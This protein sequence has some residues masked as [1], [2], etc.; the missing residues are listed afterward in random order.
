MKKILLL[1]GAL[2]AT[3]ATE[4]QAQRLSF[5]FSIGCSPPPQVYVAPAPV[6]IAP[7]PV[8]YAAPQPVYV[9]PQ[10]V[11][12]APAPV[13]VAYPTA[14]VVPA[15]A[16]YAGVSWGYRPYGGPPPRWGHHRR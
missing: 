1:A 6:Y 5:G 16:I 11:V 14:V 10:P 13:V 3:C 8:Y 7:Q 2:L 12:Y 15:P 4:T 9:A